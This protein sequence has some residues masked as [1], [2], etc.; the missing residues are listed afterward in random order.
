MATISISNLQPVGSSLFIDE[1]SFLN[2]LSDEQAGS[3]HGGFTIFALI[4]LGLASAALG[5]A[6]GRNDRK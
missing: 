4:S 6:V 2:E 1:E 5:Y 3:A